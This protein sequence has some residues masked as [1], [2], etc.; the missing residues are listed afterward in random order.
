M[1]SSSRAS[2]G[3]PREIVARPLPMS[4]ISPSPGHP[5]AGPR[6]ALGRTGP[7]PPALRPRASDALIH[8]SAKE[9]AMPARVSPDRAY[10]SVQKR[11][12]APSSRNHSTST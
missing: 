8:S 2:C 6:G 5:P 11:C 1:L 9:A 3:P 4:M 12:S 10:I 7:A